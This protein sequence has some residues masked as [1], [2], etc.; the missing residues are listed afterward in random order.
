MLV[1]MLTLGGLGAMAGVGLGLAAK[2]FHVDVDPRIQQIDDV[3]PHAQCGACGYPGCIPF[4]TAVVEGDAPADGCTVGGA[5]TAR[6]VADVMKIEVEVKS[7]EA[8]I[9]AILCKGGEKEVR[10][11]FQYD[12]FKDCSAA[13]IVAGGDKACEFACVGYGDCVRA[14]PFPGAIW[15]NDNLLP[16]VS[17]TICTGCGMCEPACPVNIIVMSPISRQVHVNCASHDKGP[18]V[19]KICDVGCIGCD[20]C[21]KA[22]PYDALSLEDNLAVMD[23]NKCTNCGLCVPVCPTK[24][25]SDYLPKRQ[26]AEIYDTC[27]G[28]DVCKKACP[29]DAIEGEYKQVYNVIKEKCI[30]CNLCFEECPVPTAIAMVNAV[31]EAEGELVQVG[32]S[33]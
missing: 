26:I 23:Y 11:K 25:I 24:T 19:K 18:V 33:G 13:K 17:P 20:I 31:P 15:M 14:C 4:A 6:D 7:E 22:C 27:I 12:G 32:S 2:K 3:L 9:A 1:E 29:V 10:K 8:V 16:E 28:C 30:G 21:I 5:K